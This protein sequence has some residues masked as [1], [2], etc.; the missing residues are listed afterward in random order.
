VSELTA[1]PRDEILR[2]TKAV[3]QVLEALRNE[4]RQTLSSLQS[5]TASNEAPTSDGKIS[6]LTKSLEQLELGV[7]EAQV[8]MCLSSPYLLAEQHSVLLIFT[9]TLNGPVL[10]C[11]LASVGVCRLS[12][13]NAAGGRVGRPP[14]AWT[15]GRP[16]LYGGPVR[17]R[18]ILILQ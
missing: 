5:A 16:T 18:P 6:M 11:S 2:K 9:G 3:S 13:S 12:L 1:M 15:V 17:L 10:F 8:C 7:S 14:G 4:H